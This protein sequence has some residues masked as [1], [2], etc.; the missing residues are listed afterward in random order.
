MNGLMQFEPLLLSRI[1]EHGA[2]TYPNVEI[3]SRVG[4]ALFRYNYRQAAARARRL[5]S[6]L[7][8]VGLK[9]GD[10]A[11]SLAW[12]TH[13][14]FELMYAVPGIGAALHAVNLPGC[15]RNISATRSITPAKG[16]YSS[17]PIVF[18]SWKS[19]HL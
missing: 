4:A 12:T 8:R 19:S 2:H 10:F 7:H 17:T 15:P 14:H 6:S 3:V 16:F 1:L 9:A 11:G 13:R 5:A 18:R